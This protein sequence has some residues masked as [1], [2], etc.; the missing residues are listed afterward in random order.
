MRRLCLAAAL[1]LVTI[2]GCTTVVKDDTEIRNRLNDLERR[3]TALE[4]RQAK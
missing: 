1:L 4:A 2:C 3:V